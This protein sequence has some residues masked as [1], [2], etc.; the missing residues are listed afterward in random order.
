MARRLARLELGIV[1]RVEIA[2][3]QALALARGSG[4]V[5]PSRGRDHSL[6]VASTGLGERYRQAAGARDARVEP[7]TAS[8]QVA[9]L[10]ALSLAPATA[11][12]HARCLRAPAIDRLVAW[13]QCSPRP[14]DAAVATLAVLT[15]A[16]SARRRGR[17]QRQRRRPPARRGRQRRRGWLRRRRQRCAGGSAP[18]RAGRVGVPR[19]DRRVRPSA[20]HRGHDRRRPAQAAELPSLVAAAQPGTTILLS[21]GLYEIGARC[22][23]SRAVSPCAPAPT[24]PP[25]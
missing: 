24:A 19:P 4:G 13:H 11:L 3:E 9:A 21:P 20:S 22:S 2:G 18:V 15:L 16:G 8:I 14:S 12:D 7:V 6:G 17:H 23:S 10:H 25:T 5:R 1:G